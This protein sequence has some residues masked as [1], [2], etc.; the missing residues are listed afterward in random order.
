MKK[1]QKTMN[2]KAYQMMKKTQKTIKK[3]KMSNRLLRRN[4]NNKKT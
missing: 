2:N 1:I 4:P 3:A